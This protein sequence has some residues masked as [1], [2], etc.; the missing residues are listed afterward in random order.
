MVLPEPIAG[1]ANDWEH[2]ADELG[3]TPFDRPGW[4]A[5]WWDAFGRGSLEVHL[6]RESGLRAVMPARRISGRRLSAT[7]WHSP[8]SGI[9]AADA[10]ALAELVARLVADRPH[11]LKIQFLD[12]DAW[13]TETLVQRL[14]EEG[15]LVRMRPHGEAS[16]L[17]IDGDFEAYEARMGKKSRAGMSRRQRQ[18]AAEGAVTLDIADGSERL[19]E[20]LEEGFA[21]EGSGWKA[22]A[23]SA[24][25]STPETER[26]YRSVARWAADRGFLFLAFLRLNGRGI[27]FEY[28]LVADGVLYGV[29]NGYDEEYGRFSPG[30]QLQA[31]V[32]R[33]AFETG[34]RRFE[35]LG[36]AE[37]YKLQ[38]STGTRRTVTLTAFA[39]TAIGRAH[40]MA[41]RYG[42]PVGKSLRDL[43]R[44]RRAGSST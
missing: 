5:A 29:K 15:Y 1:A 21:V 9:L 22:R 33:H 17:D 4:A 43:T 14:G 26:F 41:D 28:N 39:P 7:N 11:Q 44:T 38:W 13:Q 2:L 19:E 42:R 20:L 10:Q 3:A 30:R 23:G 18:L 36:V 8:K 40:L 27:A 34:L 35:F 32:V 24:I 37:G 16:F 6:V 31:A 12:A 25:T